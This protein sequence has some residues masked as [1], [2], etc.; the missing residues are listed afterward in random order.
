M[1]A[2]CDVPISSLAALDMLG[3]LGIKA[4]FVNVVDLLKIQNASEND[5]AIEFASSP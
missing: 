5:E 1:F 2:S 3:K 4:R